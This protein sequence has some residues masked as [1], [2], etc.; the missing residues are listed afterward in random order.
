[1]LSREIVDRVIVLLAAGASINQVTAR[2][3]MGRRSVFRIAHGQHSYQRP[4]VVDESPTV[5]ELPAPAGAY[6]WCPTCP[7]RHKVKMPCL[8]CG[9]RARAEEAKPA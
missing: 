5:D 6:V 1:M 7:T 4:A 9:L 2:L 8:A 3:H